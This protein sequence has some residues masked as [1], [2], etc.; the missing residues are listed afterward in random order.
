M[1]RNLKAFTV[2]Q[3]L[4]ALI[5][6]SFVII[7]AV[8][9]LRWLGRAEREQA[10]IS[11]TQSKVL[12]TFK[13]F[14]EVADAA[15]LVDGEETAVAG[16]S[17]FNAESN[18]ANPPRLIIRQE[19]LGVSAPIADLISSTGIFQD[20]NS[21]IYYGFET[22]FEVNQSTDDN[23]GD[24]ARQ[25]GLSLSHL[26]NE[27]GMNAVGVFVTSSAGREYFSR[28]TD[29]QPLFSN[30]DGDNL[31]E[32]KFQN[33]DSSIPSLS[34]AVRLSLATQ[35]SLR[36]SG[37]DLVYAKPDGTQV[38]LANNVKSFETLFSFAR[39]SDRP[40]MILPTE[41][42]PHIDV[43]YTPGLTADQRVQWRDVK[44]VLVRV[45]IGL[46]VSADRLGSDRRFEVY[47][48]ESV[49]V[50]EQVIRFPLYDFSR[51]VFQ[52]G[53]EMGLAL[54]PRENGLRGS[55]CK[56]DCATLFDSSDPESD[57]WAGY[58]RPAMD[59]AEIYTGRA[60]YNGKPASDY[61]FAGTKPRI[62]NS[63]PAS[64]QL[65][66]DIWW[67]GLI[68]RD[69][70]NSY[71]YNW[72]ALSPGSIPY[73]RIEAAISYF[74]CAFPGMGERLFIP[75]LVLSC[76]CL[77]NRSSFIYATTPSAG[78]YYKKFQ[79]D[80]TAIDAV[81]PGLAAIRGSA[82]DSDINT[83]DN[84]V[85]PNNLY[86]G[87][88][89]S[90][91]CDRQ[92]E[93]YFELDIPDSTRTSSTAAGDRARAFRDKCQ[94]E[95]RRIDSTGAVT[96]ALR[97]GSK[98]DWKSVCNLEKQFDPNADVSCSSTVALDGSNRF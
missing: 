88:Q 8:G 96:D 17:V 59:E 48:G 51:G 6:A 89:S 84:P 74:G 35:T 52:S 38:V 58:G 31:M 40:N 68:P 86:C 27:A 11:Q 9:A 34:S 55:R 70:G 2:A 7:I 19:V 18:T 87:S 67:N 21:N 63:G 5:P 23:V 60:G 69:S 10:E 24:F 71:D 13:T 16:P 46:D 33:S 93:D 57:S 32:V 81:F 1:V 90:N 78:N 47:N 50:A 25:G 76:G 95:V 53:G 45:R 64:F 15:P 80:R 98:I 4:M 36:L 79:L 42:I 39:D 77:Q 28:R 49:Y 92:L 75:H 66:E 14:Q 61:C 44:D 91:A 3:L 26:F 65:P 20:P 37:E 54:C 82:P 97:P 22:K 85:N 62:G 94:C 83:D 72:R 43:D 30:T 12:S 29:L 73:A 56:P 41:R